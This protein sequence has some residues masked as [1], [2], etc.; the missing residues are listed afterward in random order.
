MPRCDQ[1][2][3]TIGE[4]EKTIILRMPSQEGQQEHVFC[5][6]DCVRTWEPQDQQSL[7]EEVAVSKQQHPEYFNTE[8]GRS[9]SVGQAPPA[10]YGPSAEASAYRL[11]SGYQSD[12][13]EGKK[14]LLRTELE[15]AEV[16]A[17]INKL[18]EEHP[19]LN[20]EISDF[21]EID[22]VTGELRTRRVPRD[23]MDRLRQDGIIKDKDFRPT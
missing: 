10:D 1:C 19:T 9:V 8:T 22:W 5:S 11:G 20:G 17:S 21:F 15:K 2:G 6:M 14:Y 23:L 4:Q 13:S 7:E 3:K 12:Y 18:I 16:T